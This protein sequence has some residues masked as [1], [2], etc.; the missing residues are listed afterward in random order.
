MAKAA[1]SAIQIASMVLRERI[2]E[3]TA[4]NFLIWKGELIRA[5]WAI[6]LESL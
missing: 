4:R 1:R 2:V 5:R 3:R 6:Y